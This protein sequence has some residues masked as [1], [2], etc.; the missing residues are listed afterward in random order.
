MISKS[1]VMS[2]LAFQHQLQYTVSLTSSSA[3]VP[4]TQKSYVAHFFSQSLIRE[5]IQYFSERCESTRFVRI[6][7]SINPFLIQVYLCKR[8]WLDLP[9]SNSNLSNSHSPS[10]S[11]QGILLQT[12][13]LALL[14]HLRLPHLLWLYLLPLAL[15]FKLHH[16]SQN[17]P[18]MP[19]QL[20]RIPLEKCIM[21]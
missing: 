2:L 18:I 1:V 17:M 16:F 3:V 7:Q 9:H 20:C 11:I 6:N 10:H 14:L 19:P 13:T 8:G 4:L 21:G 15:P 5:M 12:N